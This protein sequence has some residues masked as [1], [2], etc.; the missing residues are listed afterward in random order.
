VP[1]AKRFAASIKGTVRTVF[2]SLVSDLNEN[3][4]PRHVGRQVAPELL[5]C[6]QSFGVSRVQIG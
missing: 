4:F 6:S 5:G 3:L 1:S 2:T